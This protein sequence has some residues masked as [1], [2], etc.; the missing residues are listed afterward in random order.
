MILTGDHEDEFEGEKDQASLNGEGRFVPRGERRGRGFRTGL[1]WRDGTDKNLGNIKMKIPRRNHER[2]IETWEEM[3]AIIR[4]WFVSSHYYRDLYQ[5]L[6]SL[7]QGYRSVDDYYKEMEIALIRANV[8]E[9]REA[10]MARWNDS[11]KGKELG[12]FKIQAPLLHGSRIGG[13]TNGAVLKFKTKPQIRKEEVPSVNKGKTESQTRNRDIKCFRCLGVDHIASQCPNKRTMIAHVNRKVE[14]ESE[15]DADQM[16]L[17]EDACNDDVEYPVE[18]ESLM[19]WRALSAQVKEDDMKQQRE[20]IFHTRCHINNKEYEDVFPN[21]VP[22]GLP[23]IRGI[24]HQID[25]VPGATIPNRPT[26][27]SNPKE[28]KELQRAIN[29]IMV[30]YR[31]PIPRLDDMLDELHGKSLDEHIDHLHCV[32]AVLR[33]EKLYANLK[34][35]SFCLDKVVFLGYVVSAKGIA[36]D[37]EKEKRPIAYFSEKLNGAALNYPTYDKELYALVRALETWQHYLWP[38]EFVIHTDHESL[39]HLKGQGKE[40]IVADALSRR[41]A[42]V[43]T[44]NAKLLG[45]EYVKELYVNDDDFASVFGAC[46]KAAFGKF[47]RLDGY[48]FRENRLCVPNSSMH[49]LLV[50][51]AH[52]G[53]RPNLESYHMAYTLLCPYLVH[54]RVDISMDFVLGLP[55]SRKGRD[56][57]FVVV[58]RFSKMAHFISCHKTDDATHIADL[59]FRE[60]VRLHGVPRSIVSDRDVKTSLDGQKKA[61]MVNKLHESVW[62]HMEKKNE[63]YATKANKGRRQVIFEPGDDSRSN[64]FKERGNDENQQAPLKD[65]LHVP[66]GP[67]Y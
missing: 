66:V 40:N 43:S 64:P 7:T 16:P 21:D 5:K 35:C 61:E 9:D 17:L 41:Y 25:F 52:G 20:N 1:R 32:L 14:T 36:V 24:E 65:P 58:D 2:T 46:E 60:I 59:F 47:Y 56:S 8:E 11:L 28:T 6:Q 34:K 50:H 29:N 27:R 63:Q 54:L 37:E 38:K 10:T 48:L 31:H 67:N 26:Y 42:L 23:P 3:R 44:L 57:I 55:R 53:G 39:K 51:E 19:A 62:Q 12:H 45:F 13:K 22:S 33:K 4:R 15:S 18:G 49:E 30:K